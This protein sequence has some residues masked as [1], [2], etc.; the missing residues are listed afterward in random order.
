[1]NEFLPTCLVST[2]GCL[3]LRPSLAVV[4]GSVREENGRLCRVIGESTFPRHV[5]S[6]EAAG[7]QYKSDCGTDKQEQELWGGLSA[8]SF[9]VGPGRPPTKP[10]RVDLALVSEA[11]KWSELML[12]KLGKRSGAFYEW[13][14]PRRCYTVEMPLSGNSGSRWPHSNA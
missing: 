12:E 7:C 3:P 1:M 11:C 2:G 5:D 13:I 6:E 10:Q 4:P 9:Q 14:L 8:G